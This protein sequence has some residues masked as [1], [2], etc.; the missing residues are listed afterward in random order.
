[1]MH[2]M[3]RGTIA[4]VNRWNKNHPPETPVVLTK[5][6]GS[7]VETKTRSGAWLLGGHTAVVMVEGISGCYL[8]ER[9]RAA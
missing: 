3:K 1:M 9:V 8:L 7:E 2:V 6:D 5:D 4:A